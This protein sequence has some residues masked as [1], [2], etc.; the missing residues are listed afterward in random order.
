MRLLITTDLLGGVWDFSVTLARALRL[1]HAA[2]VTLLALGEPSAAQR[3]EARNAGV[4]L[5][6]EPLKLEW[7]QDSDADVTATRTRVQRLAREIGADLVHANQF[8]AACIDVDVPVVLTLHSDVLSW[9]RWTLGA[10]GVPPE[11]SSY[12]S[13]VREAIQRADTVTAVSKFL[14]DQMSELYGCSKRIEVVYNGWPPPPSASTARQRLT[15]LAGRAWDA[16]KNIG[17]AAQ[18]ACGDVYL[19]GDTRHPDGGQAGVPEPLQPLGFLQRAELEEWLRRA[20]IYLS[21]AKYDPFGFLPLQAALHG[22]ALL[23]SDIPSYREV[24]GDAAVFFRSGDADDLRRQ[25]QRLLDEP[26]AMAMRAR[27]R[28]LAHYTADTTADAYA[29]LYASVPV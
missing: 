18:A 26:S 19:A 20:A 2:Q 23:L 12:A 9:R 28:A 21:P 17:L 3:V 29:R 11:W 5:L 7:M 15:L 22:C 25:W 4:S 16:A 8:A 27:E 10:S 1:R 24:W 6:A 14:A 13:L